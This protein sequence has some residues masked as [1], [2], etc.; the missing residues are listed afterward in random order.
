MGS[1]ERGRRPAWRL[2]RLAASGNTG[3]PDLSPFPEE[4]ALASAATTTPQATVASRSRAVKLRRGLT[5]LVMSLVVPGSAQLAAGSRRLGRAG[6]RVWLG[7]IGLG[8]VALVLGLLARGLLVTIAANGVVLWLGSFVVLALG[9]FWAFLVAN[10]W[11]AARPHEMGG[12][13]GFV[14]SLIAGVLV[15]ALGLGTIS[16]SAA[17]RASGSFVSTVFAGGGDTKATKGRINVLL[18]GS[19]AG[20]DREGVRTDTVMVA[21]IDADTGR[22]VLF[23]LPRNLEGVPFPASSPLKKVWPNGFECPTHECMLNAIYAQGVEHK[24]LY[25]GVK[26]P[27]VQAV[28]EAVEEILG[29]KLN[30]FA[31]VD[32]QG[33]VSLVDAV[34]GVRIDVNTRVPIPGPRGG[35]VYIE[36]TKNMLMNGTIALQYARSRHESDDFQ[37]MQRQRCVLNAMLNQLDPVTVATQFT[38]LAGA[39]QQGVITDVPASEIDRLA[40]LALKAKK[41]DTASVSFTPPLIAPGSPNWQRI[42]QTVTAEIAASE[43]LDKPQPTP[44]AQ[45]SAS[46]AAPGTTTSTA[47]ATSAGPS[48]K[49]ATGAPSPSPSASM[50]V[51]ADLAEVCAAR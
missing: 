13:R 1:Q 27:G 30:Y 18:L 49:P 12:G 8:L 22:T 39:A 32:L 2:G 7:L 46:G 5:M 42:R 38:K 47:R 34:G 6:V 20:N 48:A 51:T 11:W 44:K 45:P 4:V 40:E 21:S 41:L 31:M 24:D 37:R 23:G 29:L 36:P 26:L 3:L 25:P 15:A 10:A 19:D 16:A 35:Y 28:R 50:P 33:F 14:F 9:L 17:M 43:A